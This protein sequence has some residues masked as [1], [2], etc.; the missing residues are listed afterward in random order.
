MVSKIYNQHKNFMNSWDGVNLNSIFGVF[1]DDN[2]GTSTT[3]VRGKQNA[4]R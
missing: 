4:G 3:S 1:F 2:V